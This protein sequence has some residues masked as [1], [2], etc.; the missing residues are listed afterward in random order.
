MAIG[1]KHAIYKKNSKKIEA[2]KDLWIEKFKNMDNKLNRAYHEES[3][4]GRGLIDMAREACAISTMLLLKKL[5]KSKEKGVDEALSDSW[6]MLL[7]P[8]TPGF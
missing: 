6:Q 8:E 3:S 1:R 5:V 7:F 4:C 2:A